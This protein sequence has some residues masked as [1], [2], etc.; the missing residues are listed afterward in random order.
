M[1][2]HWWQVRA[3]SQRPLPQVESGQS[4]RAF[5]PFLTA[6]MRAHQKQHTLRWQHKVSQRK[7][8]K[9]GGSAG[10]RD[11]GRGEHRWR[12]CSHITNLVIVGME[13]RSG[14]FKSQVTTIK[15]VKGW[16]GNGL[17]RLNCTFLTDVNWLFLHSSVLRQPVIS[18][19]QLDLSPA[20]K[21]RIFKWSCCE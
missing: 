9:Q 19:N 14:F 10:W 6:L 18:S 7:K 20:P 4:A 5:S 15:Q 11:R 17:T 13:K 2:A 16:R 8:K 12:V 3:L 21:C 1:Y